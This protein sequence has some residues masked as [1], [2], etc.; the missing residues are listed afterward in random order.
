MSEI[1]SD[2]RSSLQKVNGDWAGET[3]HGMRQRGARSD[4]QRPIEH[5]TD[6][7]T[8]PS[9]IEFV[10]AAALRIRDNERLLHEQ[11]EQ[12]RTL[13]AAQAE[14][15]ARIAELEAIVGRREREH[16]ETLELLEQSWVECSLLR[17]GLRE[18][19]REAQTAERQIRSTTREID[20]LKVR[21]AKD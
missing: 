17:V 5:A 9:A 7:G 12:I 15:E 18:A 14:G 4:D 13:K 20:E 10:K 1:A 19:T 11:A 6:S 21:F 16:F 2:V 8:L 3:G